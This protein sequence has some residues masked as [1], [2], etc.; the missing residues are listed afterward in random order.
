MR[1][2]GAARAKPRFALLILLLTAGAAFT[3]WS[4]AQ[5]DKGGAI[6]SLRSDVRQA[7][8]AAS[9]AEASASVAA[10]EAR[11]VRQTLESQETAAAALSRMGYRPTTEDACRAVAAGDAAA[12]ALMTKIS[13]PS[14][15]I[16]LGGGQWATC[17][18]SALLD[19]AA[20]A[21]VAAGLNAFA[22]SAKDRD[23]LY[24]GQEIGNA[25]ERNL[26][27]RALV[28]SMVPDAGSGVILTSVRG[29]PLMY[30]VRADNAEAVEA[31]LRQGANVDEPG[32]VDVSVQT[33]RGSRMETLA[34]SPLREARRLG[35]K[36]VE[37]I[38]ASASA[39]ETSERRAFFK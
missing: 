23:R 22:L 10:V 20:S 12:L 5:A 13:A 36:R 19:S 8:V 25:N 37:P 6:A 24:V 34:T 4:R 7:A 11:S 2:V 9:Q 38:L 28:K 33:P 16:N 39:R 1:G 32:R 14:V 29:T 30:A 17:L 21:K 15:S 27:V 18:E 26:R 3:V 35:L 31:L